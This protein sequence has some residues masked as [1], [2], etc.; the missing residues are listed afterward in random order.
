MA[1]VLL[2]PTLES[3]HYEQ[4]LVVT[5]SS[6]IDTLRVY[7]RYT[8]GESAR[9]GVDEWSEFAILVSSDT[10]DST[11]VSKIYIGRPCLDFQLDKE[12][13]LL[14]FKEM[15]CLNYTSSLIKSSEKDILR[16]LN[17]EG[18]PDRWNWIPEDLELSPTNHK[19]RHEVY[20]FLHVRAGY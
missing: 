16:H 9:Q 14:I 3:S 7:K 10:T 2:Y 5:G 20:L 11:R 17:P 4:N 6:T 8:G 15:H 1:E 13:S 18:G 12:R 19:G